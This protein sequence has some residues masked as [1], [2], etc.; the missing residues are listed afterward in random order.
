MQLISTKMYFSS[1]PLLLCNNVRKLNQITRS[2]QVT[3]TSLL[4]WASLLLHDNGSK[5]YEI[6]P[7]APHVCGLRSTKLLLHYSTLKGWYINLLHNQYI[8]S[9]AREYSAMLYTDPARAMLAW[10]TVMDRVQ[11]M[12]Q[13]ENYR[14]Y[15]VKVAKV[16][17]W[18]SFCLSVSLKETGI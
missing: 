9:T 18:L 17:S 7:Q 14:I 3:K 4:F 16:F 5:P 8:W 6:Q 15:N 1:W 10:W 2:Q 12:H 13:W 11:P